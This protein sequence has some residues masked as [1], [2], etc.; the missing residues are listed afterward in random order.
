MLKFLVLIIQHTVA[1]ALKIGIR[2]LL[3][4][5]LADALIL[6]CPL[7][8]AGAITAGALQALPDRFHHFLILI[9]SDCHKT[10]SFR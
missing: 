5:F 6:L 7:Q 8:T 10:D 1:I 9:Q 2:N 3:P 4:E